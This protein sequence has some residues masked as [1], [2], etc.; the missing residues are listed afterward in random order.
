MLKVVVL[1]SVPARAQLE[2]AREA[3]P[4]GQ[5]KVAAAS[6]LLSTEIIYYVTLLL[7][8]KQTCKSVSPSGSLSVSNVVS[9]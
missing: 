7:S 4:L 1:V 2:P 6:H 8:P 9:G 5:V 3:S